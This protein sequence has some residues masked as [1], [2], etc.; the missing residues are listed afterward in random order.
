[1]SR[2]ENAMEAIGQSIDSYGEDI[3]RDK[4]P[5]VYEL[6]THLPE[7]YVVV[8]W[9]DSQNFMEEPWF[10]DEAIL[11]VDSKF[12]DSAYLIPIKYVMN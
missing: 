11:D 5:E 6:L 12:G 8:T 10:E 9:P 1:M 3:K 7:A 2:F 4:C